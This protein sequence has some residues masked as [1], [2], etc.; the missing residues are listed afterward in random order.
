[1]KA[2]PVPD[3][4]PPLVP[5]PVQV[6]GWRD[7]QGKQWT[8][9]ADAIRANVRAALARQFRPSGSTPPAME[10]PRPGGDSED[11]AEWL[12]S[13]AGQLLPYLQAWEDVR[14]GA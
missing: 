1:M 11:F 5:T 4:V 14:N 7:S 3:P 12:T 2:V 10:R 6:S 8:S 9:L 13:N